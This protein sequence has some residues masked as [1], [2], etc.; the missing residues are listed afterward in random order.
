MKTDHLRLQAIFSLIDVNRIQL[1]VRGGLLSHQLLQ[2]LLRLLATSFFYLSHP[3]QPPPGQ[4]S[5]ESAGLLSGRSR[6]RTPAGPTLRVLKSLRR[7][8]CLC[9]DICKWLDFL[10][11]SDKDEKPQVPSPSTYTYLV[12]V[13]RKRTHTTV[14]KEQETQTP[15]LWSTFT[16]HI[17]HIMGWVG[18][19]IISSQMN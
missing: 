7:K 14:R 6:V 12:L 18:T 2:F 9:N 4:L 5:W 13:G 3:I 17:I 19:V 1:V 8:C 11:F 15:V 16:H 10:V